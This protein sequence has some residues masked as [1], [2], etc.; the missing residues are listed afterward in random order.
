MDPVS[1]YLDSDWRTR[2]DYAFK[3]NYKTAPSLMFGTDQRNYLSPAGCYTPGRINF[4]GE[5]FREIITRMPAVQGVYWDENWMK[6]CNNPNHAQCG[7]HLPDGQVQGRAWWRGVREVDRRVRQAFLDN[8]R[9]DPLI[10]M[11]TGEGLIPH[12]YSFGSINYLGEHLTFDLDYIDYWTPHFT[13]IAC[14]GAWGFD[15]GILGMFREARYRNRPEL[16]RAQIALVKL[17]DSHFYPIDFNMKIYRPCLNAEKRFGKTEKDVLFAGYF[18]REGKEIVPDLPGNV[19]AS[20]WIRPGRKALVYISNLG[21]DAQTFSLKF[22]LKKYGIRE[23]KVFNG[24][25]RKTLDLSHP[26]T[27]KKHDFLLVEIERVK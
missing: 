2:P 26:V 25:T 11:F 8:N 6:P 19:K 18:T 15:V 24:E 4:L 12:A 13:E 3:A 22:D 20:T 1:R 7:Y 21:S 23:Y 5:R 27:V 10:V 16:N 9:P 17:Y 14:A